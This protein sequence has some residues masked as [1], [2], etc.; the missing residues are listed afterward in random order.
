[1]NRNV[2]IKLALL[3][4]LVF[5]LGCGKSETSNA[6]LNM[7]VDETNAKLIGRTYKDEKGILWFSLSGSGIEF[8]IT[9]KKCEL[10]IVGDSMVSDTYRTP[11]YAIYLD[12]ERIIDSTMQEEVEKIIVFESEDTQEHT[13]RL[14][15]LS[16]SLDSTMG[17]SLI[18]CDGQAIIEP[19][20]K[21]QLM[22]EFIGDS[23][24]CGYGV[25]GK[26][27]ENYSTSTEDCT[28]AYAIKVAEMLDADYSLFSMSGY[29]IVSGYT[30]D[31]HKAKEKCIPDYYTKL[32]KTDG[33]INPSFN[34]V[35]I[36]WDFTIKPDIIV[37]NLGTN[38]K[39]YVRN[40]P[41]R[42]EEYTLGYVEFLKDVREKNP[43]TPILCT[44]GVMRQELCPSVE[45][46]VNRYKSF[47]GD[48]DVYYLT[49]DNQGDEVVIDGHP[50][51]ASHQHAAEKVYKT[52]KTILEYK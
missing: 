1:M 21:K 38:D 41:S 16:E 45:D 25:D 20:D 12:G 9:G 33:N 3:L 34:P 18:T 31:G 19:T 36:E 23:I 47:T 27:G 22:I 32:G 51:E 46:A 10:T 42:T 44:L 4:F 30:S 17:V 35:D 50:T 29:G 15:K 40:N 48:E 2:F 26:Y 14:I 5:E 28:K 7:S 39:F 13:I 37:I 11:R 49:L 52:I 8:K 24:T 43:D 6:V